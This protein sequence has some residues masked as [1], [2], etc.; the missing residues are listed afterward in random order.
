ME[1]VLDGALDRIGIVVGAL[2]NIENIGGDGVEDLANNTLVDHPPLGIV[3]LGSGWRDSDVGS[4]TELVD[5]AIEEGVPL[6]IV[7]SDDVEDDRDVR[8]D[9]DGL[10]D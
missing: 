9:D 3:T 1:L 4:K 8:L 5:D 6:G 10:E 7:G 2:D